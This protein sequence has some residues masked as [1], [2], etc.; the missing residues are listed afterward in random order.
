MNSKADR[1]L[2]FR[3]LQEL[4]N[5]ESK[6]ITI[7]AILKAAHAVL[8]HLEAIGGKL[9]QDR[10]RKNQSPLPIEDSEDNSSELRA[11]IACS[12]RYQAYIASMEVM[13]SRVSKLVEMV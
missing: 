1:S 5:L 4:R 7:T 12:F 13:R 10:P 9:G 11:L 8:T 3:T 2:S 6:L